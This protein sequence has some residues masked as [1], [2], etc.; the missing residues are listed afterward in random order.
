MVLHMFSLNNAAFNYPLIIAL[1]YL[2]QFYFKD[3]SELAKW[4]GDLFSR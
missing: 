1:L 4:E 2:F 3:I